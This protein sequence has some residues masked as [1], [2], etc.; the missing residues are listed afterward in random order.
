MHFHMYL[1]LF[2]AFPIS[3]IGHESTCVLELHYFN[4]KGFA[5]ILLAVLKGTFLKAII[6][7]YW[8][9]SV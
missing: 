2:L 1:R 5:L 4:Y 9:Y 7:K 8:L 3:F 6:A